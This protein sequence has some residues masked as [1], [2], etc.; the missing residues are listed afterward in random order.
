MG[1]G[2]E[3]VL[4]EFEAEGGIMTPAPLRIPHKHARA[5]VKWAKFLEVEPQ[6]F[7]EWHLDDTVDDLEDHHG[8]LFRMGAWA[9]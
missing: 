9:H 4:C 7:F 6:T 3:R 2:L 5:L 1:I 8:L